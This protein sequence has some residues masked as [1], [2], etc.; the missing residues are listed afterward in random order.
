M[1]ARDNPR[2]HGASNQDREF[3]ELLSNAVQHFE[4]SRKQIPKVEPSAEKKRASAA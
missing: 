1:P 4:A 3:E 2:N